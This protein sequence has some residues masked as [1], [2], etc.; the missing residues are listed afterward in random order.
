[1]LTTAKASLVYKPVDANLPKS[2]RFP[3]DVSALQ[4]WKYVKIKIYVSK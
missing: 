1:M 3:S 2:V 4:L